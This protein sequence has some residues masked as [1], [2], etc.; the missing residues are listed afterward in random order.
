M[1]NFFNRFKY[2]DIPLLTATLLLA[3]AGI[4][5]LYSTTLSEDSNTL[6]YKQLIFLGIGFGGFLF[7]S[8]FNYRTLAKANRVIYVVMVGLL[9]YL[10]IFGSI[11]RG[12]RRWIDLGFF[13]FQPAEFVKLV[14]ILGLA[15]MLYLK[16]GQINSFTTLVW[17][18]A[19]ALVPA[20]LVIL[21]PDLGS[22][23]IILSL[24]LGIIMLSPIKKKFLVYLFIS[25]V[26]ISGLTWKFF[27]KEFQR[28]RIMV[29]INPELDPRGKGY[30]VKQATIAVGSGEFSGRG[31]GKGVQ[32]Q[33]KFLPERQTDF[34][35]AASSEEIGFLGSMSLLGL[36]FFLLMRLYMIMKKAKDDLGMY[37][38][39][40]ILFFFFFHVIINVGMN[41]GLL[42][43]TGIP[44]PFVSAGGSSLIVS[45]SALGVAQN[46]AIQSK[47]LRF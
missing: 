26:I 4:S 14:V 41:I 6:F 34:I 42:P 21:E 5:I 3:L 11:V 2:F 24:W 15:R 32:S 44:L 17:S 18:L 7:L 25:F 30:N 35:F 10:E 27:L 36:F 45:L 40:G 47:A 1:L 23:I 12:G 16:R 22:A 29:F 28:D 46:I 8:F 9:L 19:Y 31:L 43:V 39:G 20:G 33:H 13:T 38:A 37:I